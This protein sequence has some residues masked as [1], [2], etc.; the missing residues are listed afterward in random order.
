MTPKE[1]AKRLF[2]ESVAYYIR[3][4]S[5]NLTLTK[6]NLHVLLIG[7]NGIVSVG[8]PQIAR[9][10]ANL[11]FNFLTVDEVI[12]IFERAKRAQKD[13]DCTIHWE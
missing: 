11:V 9:A 3:C 10:L 2:V 12:E 4:M 5:R 8:E 13:N 6:E 7:I 1:I